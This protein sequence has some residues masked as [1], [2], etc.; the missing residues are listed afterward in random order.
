MVA[1]RSIVRGRYIVKYVGDIRIAYVGMS[2]EN[3]VRCFV[4]ENLKFSMPK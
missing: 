1:E 4:T 3:K 2:N